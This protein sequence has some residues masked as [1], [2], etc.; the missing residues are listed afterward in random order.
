M[1]KN[2]STTNNPIGDTSKSAIDDFYRSNQESIEKGLDT[3]FKTLNNSLYTTINTAFAAFTTDYEKRLDQNREV[4][5]RAVASLNDDL[6]KIKQSNKTLKSQKKAQQKR[7]IAQFIQIQEFKKKAQ[8]F[9]CLS[10]YKYEKKAKNQR[11]EMIINHL[12]FRKKLLIFNSWRNIANSLVKGKIKLQF[13]NAYTGQQNQMNAEFDNEMMKLK[14]VLNN[15]E[16]DI[17][18]EMEERRALS[19]LYDLTMKKG[20]E[21]FLKETNYIVDFNSSQV[22]TPHERSFAE[23]NNNNN[24]IDNLQQSRG[25]NNNNNNYNNISRHSKNSK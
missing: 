16:M 25:S 8:L 3:S 5:E 23:N 11:H 19:K 24:N 1:S 2:D 12:D 6:K 13:A 4:H 14:E 20:V 9:R 18:K 17:Q 21:A 10:K 7:I 22:P 15:L